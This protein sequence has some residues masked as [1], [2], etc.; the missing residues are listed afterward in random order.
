VKLYMKAII[1]GFE[2]EKRKKEEERLEEINNLISSIENIITQKATDDGIDIDQF[3]SMI[4]SYF[5]EKSHNINLDED[6]VHSL[7]I[8]IYGEKESD[9]TEKSN[10][11]QKPSNSEIRSLKSSKYKKNGEYFINILIS[12]K[13]RYEEKVKK[14][15]L[16]AKHKVPFLERA[17]F[18]LD[19][20]SELNSARQ[21][22][23]PLPKLTS[24][25]AYER[26]ETIRNTLDK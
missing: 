23:K 17:K 16:D 19:A 3:K 4:Y 10:S 7:Y 2:E 14:E 24:L 13:Q 11:S 18:P 15:A 12:G 8:A 1:S 20:L 9:N 21:G 26:L 22:Y 5:F 6:F 25:E